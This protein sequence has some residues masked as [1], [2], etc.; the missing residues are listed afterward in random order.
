LSSWPS[1]INFF[2]LVINKF[3]SLRKK[4][5]INKTDANP[6]PKLLM[7]ARIAFKKLGIILKFILELISDAFSILMNQYDDFLKKRLFGLLIVVCCSKAQ[8]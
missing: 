4:N 3:R 8:C 6:I 2:A 7:V 5:V 1:G